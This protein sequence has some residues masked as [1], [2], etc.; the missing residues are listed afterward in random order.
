MPDV[1]SRR[2]RS[3]VMAKIRGRGN[4]ETELVLASMLRRHGLWGW[5]RHQRILGRPDFAF[6]QRRVAVFVD[7]CFWHGCGRHANVPA[8]NRKFWTQKLL[9]N[10]TRDRFV[11]R[12]LR[13]HG[14]TVVRIWEH[15]LKKT[16][17]VLRKITTALTK[18]QSS[19]NA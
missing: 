7:G 14:W 19:L 8:N 12:E 18:M 13:R 16:E 10:K 3:E 11:T 17:R 9:A 2:K 1:F 4:K 6:R 5:R 15:E